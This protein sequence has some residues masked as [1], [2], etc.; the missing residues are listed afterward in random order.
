MRVSDWN[1]CNENNI[2]RVVSIDTERAN[3]LIEV[4]N[5]RIKLIRE[6]NQKN[7]NFVFEDYYTSLL[8]LLQA[9]VLKAGYNVSNHLC[10]GYYLRDV[11]NR[12]D[13]Y[14]IL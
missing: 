1:E 8:E 10:L 11:L 7:C 2:T 5:A 4:S 12:R 3:S 14:V 13:L 9:L 6:I